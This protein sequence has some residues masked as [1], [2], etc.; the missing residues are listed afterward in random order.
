M[1]RST[2]TTNAQYE[3]QKSS[4]NMFLTPPRKCKSVLQDILAINAQSSQKIVGATN[5][6][7]IQDQVTIKEIKLRRIYDCNYM[8]Q[9]VKEYR[10]AVIILSESNIDGLNAV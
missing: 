10:F 9:L 3:Y 7:L 2:L 4:L 8:Y 1:V 6:L 5:K